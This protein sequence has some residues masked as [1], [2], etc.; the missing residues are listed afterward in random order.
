MKTEAPEKGRIS[1]SEKI[2]VNWERLRG[3]IQEIALK[4]G[5]PEDD[6]FILADS[7][8][9]ADLR[10]IRSHGLTRLP[11][12]IKRIECGLINTSGEIKVLKESA[13]TIY[14]DACNSLGSVASVKALR[15]AIKKAR[16]TGCVTLSIKG[17]NHYGSAAYYTNLAAQEGMIGFTCTGCTPD[18]A[19]WGS[20]E[21]YIGTNPFSISAPTG[22][23]ILNLDMATSVQAKGKIR[24]L[25]DR[26]ERIPEGWCLDAEGNPTTDPEKAI[27]GTM[28]PMGG[29]K[30]YGMAVFVDV[31]ASILSGGLFGKYEPHFVT[32]FEHI[33]ELG[34]FFYLLDIE[35]IMPL[36]QFK[37]RLDWMISDIK[38]LPLRSGFKEIFLPGEIEAKKTEEAKKNGIEM[39]DTFCQCIR[40]LSEKFNVPLPYETE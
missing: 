23:G 3:F 40:E 21:R 18:V 29:A 38:G 32:D 25:A 28:L 10:G 36:D 4:L 14:V 6:A 1:M 13:S 30:G 7:L 17:S 2:M 11:T 22:S 39:D 34:H 35:K 20:Y 31:V 9:F 26:G 27:A 15:L 24:V 19:P 8:V 5:L 16:E 37:K 12:Y 33:S